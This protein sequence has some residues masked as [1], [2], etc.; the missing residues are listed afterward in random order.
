MFV[1]KRRTWSQK[2]AT[3]YLSVGFFASLFLI[4]RYAS[5]VT[6]PGVLVPLSPQ[7]NKLFGTF[8]KNPNYCASVCDCC[9]WGRNSGSGLGGGGG[10]AGSGCGSG[11]G[12][13]SVVFDG[14]VKQVGWVVSEDFSDELG[15]LV[16]SLD[17]D[18]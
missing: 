9:I 3:D 6:R 15:S 4:N 18:C 8:A 13:D 1:K 10:G 17:P 2:L 11:S 14:S 16:A 7:R 12:Q 5:L